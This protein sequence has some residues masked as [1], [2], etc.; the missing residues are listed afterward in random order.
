MMWIASTC[1]VTFTN[2]EHM[3][4]TNKTENPEETP[5]TPEE[6]KA[7]GEIELGPAKHEVFLNKHYKKLIFGGVALAVVA[8]AATAWYAYGEQQKKEA[9]AQIVSSFAPRT[10]INDADPLSIVLEDY[11]DTPSAETATYIKA[12]RDLSD[13]A[14]TDFSVMQQLAD[15]AES[16][17]V[18]L[19][20]CHA[21][22]ARY[23]KDGDYD[24][25]TLYLKKVINFPR[26]V[27]TAHAYIC[28]SDIAWNKGDKQQ[29]L[30]YLTEGRE[31]CPD[32]PLFS[33]AGGTGGA[34]D[35]Y[36]QI[37]RNQVS[38]R[39]DMLES[40][41]DAPV[42]PIFAT[43]IET[44]DVTVPTVTGDVAVPAEGAAEAPVAPLPPNPATELPAMPSSTLEGVTPAPVG[45]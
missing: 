12:A 17:S 7:I 23:A 6:V 42:D 5:L 40:G 10:N 39:F 41:V 28:L 19:L 37:L 45:I 43:P 36:Y 34:F 38:V 27:Y 24:N 15:N 32:S 33:E 21:L 16:E 3:Q 35:L 2:P 9:G 20:A 11:P 18:R 4:T 26:N 13:P 44:T 14:Y 25:A 8:S 30:M 29:A 22:A 1:S 31:T